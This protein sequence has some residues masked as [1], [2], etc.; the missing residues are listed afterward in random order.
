MLVALGGTLT[1]TIALGAQARVEL[2]HDV[3][4]DTAVLPPRLHDVIEEGFLDG[5]GFPWPG[6]G[7]EIDLL[8]DAGQRQPVAIV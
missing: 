7:F 1:C 3:D 5:G 2:L 8:I 6:E 4:E